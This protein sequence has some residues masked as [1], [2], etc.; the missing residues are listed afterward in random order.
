MSYTFDKIEKYAQYSQHSTCIRC[1]LWFAFQS[2][3]FKLVVKASKC[4][5]YFQFNRVNK[6]L[7]NEHKKRN[8]WKNN[9]PNKFIETQIQ[10]NNLRRI[11]NLYGILR[12]IRID[13]GKIFFL[14]NIQFSDIRIIWT[15]YKILCFCA[16]TRVLNEPFSSFDLWKKTAFPRTMKIQLY[17]PNLFEL[18]F[19]TAVLI[20]KWPSQN[21]DYSFS[22]FSNFFIE[23]AWKNKYLIKWYK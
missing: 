22:F 2:K 7:L 17:F 20:T 13:W 5:C 10:I 4:C 21:T 9:S 23:F 19:V 1:G 12:N 8:I 14:G 18:K 15:N 11:S 3:P 16:T 6:L